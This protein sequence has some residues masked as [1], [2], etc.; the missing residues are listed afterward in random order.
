MKL[1]LVCLLAGVAFAKENGLV[2]TVCK[3]LVPAAE[4]I[5]DDEFPV[6]LKKMHGYC[7]KLIP[8]VR[9]YCDALLKEFSKEL[10][11]I[12][13][14]EEHHT[15]EQVCEQLGMCHPKP[16]LDATTNGMVCTVCMDLVP[17]ARK[18]ET[19]EL[20]VFLS[21]LK[22]ECAKMPHLLRPYCG[23]LV[24]ELGTELWHIIHK[25]GNF[26]DKQICQMVHMCPMVK[27]A[28]NE[29]SNGMVCTVCMD[30]VPAARKIET[31][32]LPVF[33]KELKLVCNKFPHLLQ[34]YCK[35][36]VNELG[37]ELWH[38]IHKEG[39]FTDKQ[40]CQM[41]HMCP[42]NLTRNEQSNGVVCT[43][44]M[45]LVPTARKIETDELS[46]FL[47]QLT[48]ECNKMPHLLRPYCQALVKEVGTEL[49]ALIHKEEHL[50]DKE[51]CQRL[52]M[53][54]KAT[55]NQANAYPFVCNLCKFIVPMAEQFGDYELLEFKNAMD[56]LCTKFGAFSAK[57]SA[58]VDKYAVKLH[59]IL[60]RMETLTPEQVCEELHLCEAPAVEATVPNGHVCTMC[61]TVTKYAEKFADKE[62]EVFQRELDAFCSHLGPLAPACTKMVDTYS[63]EIWKLLNDVEKYTPLQICQKLFICKKS[64]V[65][66]QKRES[67]GYPFMCEFCKY[68]I[69]KAEKFADFGLLEFKNAL[70]GECKKL[71]PFSSICSELVDKYAVKLHE[72]IQRAKTL[73]P[74]QMC[75]ELQLCSPSAAVN[76]MNTVNAGGACHMCTS[77][78]KHAEQFASKDITVFKHEL[79]IFCN[80]LGPLARECKKMVDGFADEMYKLLNDVEHHT[81]LEICQKMRLCKKTSNVAEPGKMCNIC[82]YLVEHAEKYAGKELDVFTAELEKVCSY[83]GPLAREC[84][85][86][87]DKYAE[88]IHRFINDQEHKYTPLEICQKIHLCKAQSTEN[89]MIFCTVCHKLVPYAEMIADKQLPEFKKELELICNNMGPFAPKCVEIVDKYAAKLQQIVK[90]AEGKSTE[91]VCEEVGLC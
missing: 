72:I 41:L 20:P 21:E 49:W 9:P 16:Q 57:C 77:L 17:A 90:K 85:K 27:I 75:Q 58:F 55:Q 6:F 78:V 60:Q 43:V 38:I 50:T 28:Q 1:L 81:A 2:C 62:L 73:T 74:E 88:E 40:I 36:L 45:D 47:K 23:A 13:H 71:G 67:N 25:E 30:L 46:V 86:V 24:K 52:H 31:Q 82:T 22:K 19:D 51:I 89:G 42:V 79:D 44:C 37:T 84:K 34:P 11:T 7:D 68:L 26:T 18:I 56:N 5:A 32:E 4:K 39:N 61:Q 15:V 64:V 87:V 91:E 59:K 80:H 48:A 65:K 8:L 53:C 29:E 83:L 14:H 66:R 12:L 70:D 63:E 35:A 54:P 33:L 76:T 3:D 69:P 10:Y